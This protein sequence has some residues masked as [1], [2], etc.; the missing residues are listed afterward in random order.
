MYG[1]IRSR[2]LLPKSGVC[3]GRLLLEVNCGV[4]ESMVSGM[5]V[6]LGSLLALRRSRRC[7]GSPSGQ[8]GGCCR[9]YR[10][11][12]LI[13]RR[14]EGPAGRGLALV[15]ARSAFKGRAHTA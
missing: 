5:A 13:W 4:L 15:K 11:L 1:E 9:G 10:P 6:I 14:P 3:S 8:C 12:H 7:P 2:R